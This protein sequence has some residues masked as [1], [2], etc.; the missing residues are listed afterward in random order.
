MRFAPLVRPTLLLRTLG[1][2]LLFAQGCGSAQVS[3][4]D[5]GSLA[6]IPVPA[7]ACKTVG[8]SCT[9]TPAEAGTAASC[10][11]AIVP[12]GHCCAG[13][14]YPYA[15]DCTCSGAA[16]DG[17]AAVPSCSSPPAY[18]EAGVCDP[19]TCGG[20]SCAGG[21]CCTSSCVNGA[22]QATCQ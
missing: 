18:I 15:G 2:L 7:L 11:D 4:V 13:P 21:Y 10:D 20:S 22:C 9:C 12:K 14:D 17:S 6:P 8:A 16:C 1:A 3:S 19:A 5:S